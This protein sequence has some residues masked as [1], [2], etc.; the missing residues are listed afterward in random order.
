MYVFDASS[1]MTFDKTRG[2]KWYGLFQVCLCFQFLFGLSMAVSGPSSFAANPELYQIFSEYVVLCKIVGLLQCVFTV[3]LLKTTIKYQ[4]SMLRWLI[5]YTIFLLSWCITS[6][7]FLFFQ[8]GIPINIAEFIYGLIVISALPIITYFYLKKRWFSS[9]SESD[10]NSQSTVQTEDN[11]YAPPDSS[12]LLLKDVQKAELPVS[13]LSPSAH[14]S[15]I[16]FCRFCGNPLHE[17][18][19]FCDKCGKKVRS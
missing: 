5:V 16:R 9:F 7:L 12:D 13:P 10:Q 2:L 8:Y 18:S 11:I 1:G 3:L 15:K 6:Y 19:M 4:Y 14:D 17:D